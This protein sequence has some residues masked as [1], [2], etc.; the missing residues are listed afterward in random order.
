MIKGRDIT[1]NVINEKRI[2]YKRLAE[3]FAMKYTEKSKD[4]LKEKS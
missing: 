3:F 2:N 4:N 1:I